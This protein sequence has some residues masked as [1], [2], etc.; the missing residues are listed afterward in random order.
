M[1]CYWVWH[2][3]TLK[4]LWRSVSTLYIY[5]DNINV[6]IIII[7][8]IQLLDTFFSFLRRKTDFYTGVESSK[9]EQV[10]T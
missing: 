9:A 7:I 6:I 3:S 1:A 4:V 5:N 8:I 2:N 10:S